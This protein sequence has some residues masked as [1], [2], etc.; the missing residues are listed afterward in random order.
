MRL[1]AL[2][3]LALVACTGQ[4]PEV[5]PGGMVRVPGG[6]VKLGMPLPPGPQGRPPSEGAVSRGAKPIPLPQR[7]VV[8]SDFEIDVTEVTRVAY[9]AFLVDTGYRPPFV[10]EAWAEDG[11]N[12][13]GT[14][15]PEGTKDH[16]VVLVSWYDARAYCA[17]A[18]KR[19]PTEAEWL[20]AALGPSSEGRTWPW[21]KEYDAKKL[22]HGQRDPPNYDPS[23][24]YER[25]SPVTAFPGGRS[26]YGLFDTYGNAWEWTADVRVRDWSETTAG[27]GTGPARDP[28]TGTVGLYAATRGGSYFG[29]FEGIDVGQ[30]NA[31]PVQLRRKSSGFRCARSV[32]DATPQPLTVPGA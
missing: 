17:W 30:E 1:R 24:G 5:V 10:A 28:R 15:Y 9:Q 8:V 23:D 12:W 14:D 2:A 7:E 29:G 16:P 4:E 22:N 19:L 11:W 27:A 18:D 32:G 20:L 31:F 21:G 25:T 13:R 3:L 6:T 26:P